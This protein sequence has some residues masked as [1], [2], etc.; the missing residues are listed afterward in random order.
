MKFNLYIYNR[1]RVFL[2]KINKIKKP[3]LSILDDKENNIIYL[4]F[5]D[6]DNFRQIT[7][8]DLNI[9]TGSL[10]Y[11]FNDLLLYQQKYFK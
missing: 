7:E 9:N 10:N 6:K 5:K 1:K 4:I 8:I 3:N 11:I 2:K